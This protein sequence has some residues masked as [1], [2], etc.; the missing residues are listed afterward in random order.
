MAAA[1]TEST[2]TALPKAAYAFHC[3]I[4]LLMNERSVTITVPLTA[5]DGNSVNNSS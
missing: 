4:G 5:M 3:Y 2:A 1:K